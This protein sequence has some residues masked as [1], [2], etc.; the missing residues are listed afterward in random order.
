MAILNNNILTK[1]AWMAV[2]FPANNKKKL[3][4]KTIN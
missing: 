4:A 1:Q 3:V 2:Y